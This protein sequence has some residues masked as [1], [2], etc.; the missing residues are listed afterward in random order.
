MVLVNL[1]PRFEQIFKLNT[2]TYLVSQAF[3]DCVKLLVLRVDLLMGLLKHVLD[4]P[5]CAIIL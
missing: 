2:R 5:K 3:L 1:A 4:S